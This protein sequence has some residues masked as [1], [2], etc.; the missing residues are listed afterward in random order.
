MLAPVHFTTTPGREKMLF[1]TKYPIIRSQRGRDEVE[2]RGLR[3]AGLPLFFAEN[4]KRAYL[5]DAVVPDF[6]GFIDLHQSLLNS[7]LG[8]MGGLPKTLQNR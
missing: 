3:E 4:A 5:W 1:G 6:S 7:P 2:A 8:M